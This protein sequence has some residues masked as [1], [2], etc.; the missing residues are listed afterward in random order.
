MVVCLEPF[1]FSLGHL[2]HLH[3]GGLL[4]RVA[5]QPAGQFA[6]AFFAALEEVCAAS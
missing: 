3:I 5:A 4:S 6:A 2:T 1:T